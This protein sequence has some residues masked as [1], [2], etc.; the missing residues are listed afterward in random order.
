MTPHRGAPTIHHLDRAD[1]EAL[2]RR[3]HV[4]RLAFTFHDRVDIEPIH[5][6]FE[7]G[8]IF[9]R[10]KFGTKVSVLAH[11]PW[12][13]FEVDEVDGLHAWQSVVVHGQ[14]VFPDPEGAPVEHRQYARG[15]A[16]LRHL[17]PSAFTSHDPT[18]DRDLVFAFCA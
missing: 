10:T 1:C 12:V 13:A 15:V 6:V 11:H 16:T 18:P 14:I 3:H 4:G 9:G 8:H 17:V 5:Y 7:D 2:L